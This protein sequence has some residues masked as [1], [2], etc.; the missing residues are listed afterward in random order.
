[1]KP[2]FMTVPFD[3]W[4]SLSTIGEDCVT[5]VRQVLESEKQTLQRDY[6]R[7]WDGEIAT[8]PEERD[9]IRRHVQS[10]KMIDALLGHVEDYTREQMSKHAKA[11]EVK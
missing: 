8:T 6:Q 1:M 11:K 5:D 9:A 7:W 4:L 3:L 10:I 2:D